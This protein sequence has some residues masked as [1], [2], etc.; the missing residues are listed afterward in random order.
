MTNMDTD[1]CSC[2]LLQALKWFKSNFRNTKDGLI[3]ILC[4]A[5]ALHFPTSK[6]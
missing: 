2:I 1:R 6:L 3:G 4:V 5:N